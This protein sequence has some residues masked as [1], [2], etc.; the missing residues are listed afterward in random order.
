LHEI[1]HTYSLPYKEHKLVI[2]FLWR[3]YFWWGQQM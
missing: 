1:W 2:K 3:H